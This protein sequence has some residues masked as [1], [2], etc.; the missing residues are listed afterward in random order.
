MYMWTVCLIHGYSNDMNLKTIWIIIT[1]GKQFFYHRENIKNLFVMRKMRKS[2]LDFLVCFLLSLLMFFKEQISFE[3][4][5]NDCRPTGYQNLDNG[6]FRS[7]QILLPSPPLRGSPVAMCGSRTA[8]FSLSSS[9]GDEGLG[10]HQ[11][12]PGIPCSGVL[13]SVIII[14]CTWN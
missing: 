3:G 7:H 9:D 5:K 4:G 13:A 2:L 14:V 1:E 6:P 12:L 10:R 8:Q 11:P